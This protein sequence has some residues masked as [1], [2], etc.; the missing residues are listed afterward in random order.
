MALS[1][2]KTW[3]SAEVLAASD[4][5]AEF[6]SILNNA[7]SLISPLTGTLDLNG[8]TLSSNLI[9]SGT[10]P[11]AIGGSTANNLR[12]QLLGTFTS[13]G[14]GST[15]GG[16]V[17]SGGLTGL[18]GD[19]SWHTGTRLANTITTQAVAETINVVSQLR[20]EEPSITIGAGST[21]TASAA[22]YIVGAAT[23]ATNDYA[24]WVDAGAVQIDENLTVSAAVIMDDNSD[25]TQITSLTTGVTTTTRT[26][27]ITTHN[28]GTVA[29]G[30]ETTFTVTPDAADIAVG[31]VVLVCVGTQFTTG[32]T[33]IDAFCSAVAANSFD[34]TYTNLSGTT[35]DASDGAAVI[36]YC[37]IRTS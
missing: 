8:Q 25:D 15:M 13:G 32:S 36:N 19:T 2:V 37:I 6:N 14:A 33:L 22:V 34:I 3:S 30:V 31:D 4:L 24:L 12:H 7:L 27:S 23:E 18:S 26:G 28:V 21:V 35:I 9:V 1:R 16:L 17:V 20:V 11:H 5:N 10:G 29:A